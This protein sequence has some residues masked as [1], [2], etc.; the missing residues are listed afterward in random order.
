MRLNRP[1]SALMHTDAPVCR[2]VGLRVAVC[3]LFLINASQAVRVV[4]VLV[5]VELAKK[6]RYMVVEFLVPGFPSERHNYMLI[7]KRGV[8]NHPGFLVLPLIERDGQ[9]PD[10]LLDRLFKLGPAVV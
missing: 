2:V 5:G 6:G 10:F 9:S 4:V 7:D 8:R 1:K 3:Y